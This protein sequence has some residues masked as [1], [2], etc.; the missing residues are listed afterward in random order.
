VYFHRAEE[1]ELRAFMQSGPAGALGEPDVGFLELGSACI[2]VRNR[3]KVH[4]RFATGCLGN[5]DVARSSQR[6]KECSADESARSGD[7]YFHIIAPLPMASPVLTVS[8]VSH[9]QNSL[10]NPLLR[11]LAGITDGGCDVIVTENTADAVSVEP[12]RMRSALR[13]IVNRRP[14]GFGANHNRAF[15]QC[16][17]PY[18]CVCNPDVRLRTDP[19]P[20]LQTHF[21]SPGVGVVAPL[22]RS[23]DGRLENNA[24]RFPTA[25]SLTR[26]LFHRVDAPEYPIDQ[27]AIDADW[28]GGMFMVFRAAAYQ[29]V[30][31]FD[32]A[33]FLYYEDVDL[34]RRLRRAGLRVIYEPA[35]EVI[36]DAR[37]GSRRNLRLMAH[38]LASMA[39]YLSRV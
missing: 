23:P 26:K 38:L 16:R 5:E 18:F 1:Y 17:T 27:G 30:G 21:A 13:R 35:A 12:P 33:Y 36:H 6:G 29:A 9:G 34:C 22:V 4:D 28:V 20:A 39:R 7:V 31:G 32:E 8:I 14:L 3:R 11:D 37:R 2:A 19:F 24:R 10:V 15:A 25:V